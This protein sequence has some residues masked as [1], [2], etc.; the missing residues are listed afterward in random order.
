M[1]VEIIF[2]CFELI[3]VYF[4]KN[5]IALWSWLGGSIILYIWFLIRAHTWV[6]GSILSWGT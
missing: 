5:K 2:I 6:A 1:Y 3:A 4:R